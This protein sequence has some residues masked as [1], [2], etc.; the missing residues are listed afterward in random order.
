MCQLLKGN[1]SGCWLLL[2]LRP[3]QIL[4]PRPP[5]GT[6]AV[7]VQAALAGAG[8]RPQCLH[9]AG[10]PLQR[11]LPVQ[12]VHVRPTARPAPGLAGAASTRGA[13]RAI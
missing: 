3:G 13:A 6:S 1:A 9:G 11:P 10:P 2:R 12:P 4:C 5:A 7:Q 8:R